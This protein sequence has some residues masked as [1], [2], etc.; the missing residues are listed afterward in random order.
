MDF[1]PNQMV[2]TIKLFALAYSLYDDHLIKKEKPD[3]AATKCAKIAVEMLP[4]LIEF[5]GYTF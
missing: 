1:T 4:S 3:W 2:I 5:I